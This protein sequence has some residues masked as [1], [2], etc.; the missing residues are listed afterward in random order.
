MGM[1]VIMM[2]VMIMVMMMVM[3]MV[4]MMAVIV[5]VVVMLMVVGVGMSSKDMI[6]ILMHNS[7]PPYIVCY[8][9]VLIRSDVKTFIFS[10]KPQGEVAVVSKS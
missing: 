10:R 1:I 4:M 2:M 7:I 6:V 8:I 5:I 9:I 3:I